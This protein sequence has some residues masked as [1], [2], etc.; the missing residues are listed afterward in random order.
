[1]AQLT[2][3]QA[4][5]PNEGGGRYFKVSPDESKQVRF[6]IDKW[7]DIAPWCFG[8]HELSNVTPDG[9]RT[10]NTVDC[11][12]AAGDTT[13]ECR[14][15]SSGN[16]YVKRVVIPVFNIEEGRIQYWKRSTTWVMNS[17]K[18]VLEE[19][20]H[21]PSIA[22]QTF[23]IKRT[24]SDMQN[25]NYNILPVMNASDTRVAADFGELE[26]PMESGVIKKYGEENNQPQQGQQ[27]FAPQAG[28][29][30]RRTTE[31]F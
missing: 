4:S 26:H 3:E 14:H 19:V 18:P 28:Y 6:L 25:T 22:N 31:V 8:V 21:L 2:L 27:N 1:M 16:S 10:F 17:L 7:E 12:R 11:P 15:C 9:K 20:A 5:Q 24:G 13:A 23:K 29:Q 30:S